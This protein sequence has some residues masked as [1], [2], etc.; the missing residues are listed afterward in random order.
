MTENSPKLMS[1]NNNVRE[2]REQL[3]FLLFLI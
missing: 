2:P 3:V 1:G